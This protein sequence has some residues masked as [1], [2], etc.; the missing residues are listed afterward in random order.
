MHW[1]TSDPHFNHHNIIQYC[2]RPFD[3]VSEMNEILLRN[4]NSRVAEKDTLYVLGDW[5]F[6]TKS[7]YLETAKKFRRRIVCKDVRLIFGNH[8]RP[9][10]AEIFRTAKDLE[11]VNVTEDTDKQRI[12][13]CH[14]ALRT[15]HRSGKGA[16][17]L[18]G[19]S[20]GTLA[21]DPHALSLDVGVDC[22]N[23]APISFD[24]VRALMKQKD[25]KPIDH[26]G[27]KQEDSL[28]EEVGT[29]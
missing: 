29:P 5:C 27:Q 18:Y 28:S 25:W 22:H 10:L 16:W 4:I 7:E 3:T 20:H 1:F 26:H 6:A 15:W 17:H 9:S 24:Q 21:D 2:N 23:Y 8:D 13:L 11:T 12:V 19:H 14:Y